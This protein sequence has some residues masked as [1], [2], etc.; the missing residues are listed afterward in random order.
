MKDIIIN[1]PITNQYKTIKSELIRRHTASHEKKVRQV[2][3]PTRSWKI[4]GCHSSYVNFKIWQDQRR[5]CGRSGT[6]A[7]Q[8][9]YKSCWRPN[10]LISWNSTPTWQTAS[11]QL[12]AT[13]VSL[14]PGTLKN[15][16]CRLTNTRNRVTTRREMTGAVGNG[17]SPGRL[18]VTDRKTS[19][20]FLV[21]TGSDLCVF[22]R[23][24]L[25]ERRAAT[26]YKL[27]TASRTTIDTYYGYAYLYLDL[28]LRRSPMAVRCSWCY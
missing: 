9:T 26:N 19:T 3:Q 5:F 23:S 27:T 17:D 4:E 8:G 16:G 7:Y 11:D 15:S 6:I 22:P 13:D 25:R 28:G 14:F 18:L 24:Q 20:Q 21:E 12:P 10:P 2:L 1:P